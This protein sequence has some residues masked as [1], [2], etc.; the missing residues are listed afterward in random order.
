MTERREL[1]SLYFTRELTFS[2]LQIRSRVAFF[3]QCSSLVTFRMWFGKDIWD[4]VNAR[5]KLSASQ[6]PIKRPN[7]TRLYMM[8][9]RN[10]LECTKIEVSPRYIAHLYEWNWWIMCKVNSKEFIFEY[11]ENHGLMEH[12]ASGTSK[13]HKTI[14]NIEGIYFEFHSFK[15]FHYS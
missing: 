11:K 12:H 6:A 9:T 14:S 3:A 7:S 10:I 15:V 2:V 13:L 5:R 1:Y 4:C 8:S